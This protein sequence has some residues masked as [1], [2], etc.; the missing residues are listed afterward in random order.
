[1]ERWR[2]H[3][4][5]EAR[6]TLSYA[7]SNAT[8]RIDTIQKAYQI[9][10]QIIEALREK[11]KTIFGEDHI[12]VQTKNTKLVHDVTK[13]LN[14]KFERTSKHDGFNFNGTHNGIRICIYGM[15][16][17]AG[18]RIVPK[19]IMVEKTIYETICNEK[20]SERKQT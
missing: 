10:K 5:K 2:K 12:W 9:K 8:K 6:T 17:V 20:D 4:L 15:E 18:C 3:L 7:V 19:K 1:M 11:P 16:K 13:A 14:I